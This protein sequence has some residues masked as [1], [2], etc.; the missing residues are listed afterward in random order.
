[1]VPHGGEH[2]NMV[3]HYQP[4]SQKFNCLRCTEHRVN[5][6]T[7]AAYGKI[8]HF[9]TFGH[10]FFT[11]INEQPTIVAQKH[12]ATGEEWRTTPSN[13]CVG[14]AREQRK[15][16]SG[17]KKPKNHQLSLDETFL[18]RLGLPGATTTTATNYYYYYYCYYCYY[19]YYYYQ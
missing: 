10:I 16:T 3:Y 7:R 11:K 18:E 2:L 1:M 13:G 12:S 4:T 19:C 15:S 14:Y 6:D 9:F 5:A 8:P 17:R